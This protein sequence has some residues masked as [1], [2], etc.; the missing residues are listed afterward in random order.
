MTEQTPIAPWQSLT[1]QSV[2]V[3]GVGMLVQL[4]G[5]H[6]D[7]GSLSSLIGDGLTLAGLIGAYWGRVRTS[8]AI[9]W[10]QG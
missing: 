9:A 5:G 7:T 8:R 4:L 2:A 1:L 3:A 10:T 6:A